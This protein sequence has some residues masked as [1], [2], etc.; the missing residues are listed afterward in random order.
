[1]MLD[2]YEL[3]NQHLSGLQVQSLNILQKFHT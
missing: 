3:Q 2:Q 1:M